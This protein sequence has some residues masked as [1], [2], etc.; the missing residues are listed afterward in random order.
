M[1]SLI[2]RF[3]DALEGRATISV[4]DVNELARRYPYFFVPGVLLLEQEKKRGA[5][6]DEKLLQ[7]VAVL[8]PDR[9]ALGK[10]I[11]SFNDKFANFYPA[12]E[13]QVI[14]TDSTIDKFL[15]RYGNNSSRE[16]SALETVIFNPQPDYASVLAKQSAAETQ[17]EYPQTEEDRMI[18]MFISAQTH[19]EE[20]EVA[21]ALEAEPAADDKQS[22]REIAPSASLSETLASSYIKQRKYKEALDILEKLSKSSQQASNQLL[23]DRIRFLRKL[24]IVSAAG[25]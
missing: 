1:D 6:R 12:E 18:A 24:I 7:S 22:V 9:K 8:S 16:I 13:P 19:D 20:Q 21:V 15:N 17:P 25:K 23:S 14:D 4:D 11:G 10:I 2:S 3:N 5:Q